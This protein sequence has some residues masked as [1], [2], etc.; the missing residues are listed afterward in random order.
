MPELEKPDNKLEH[1]VNKPSVTIHKESTLA[2]TTEQLNEHT[3]LDSICDNGVIASDK[4]TTFTDSRVVVDHL[5]ASWTH[6]S[7]IQ[8]ISQ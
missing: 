5:S 3:L 6:V 2:T 7:V 8:V 4:K 1:F